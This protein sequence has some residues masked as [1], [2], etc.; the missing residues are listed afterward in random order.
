MQLL[1]AKQNSMLLRP[2]FTYW[3]EGRSALLCVPPD[4]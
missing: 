4:R 2:A 3:C 1:T